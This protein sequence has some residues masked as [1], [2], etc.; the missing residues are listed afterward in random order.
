MHARV[1]VVVVVV[2]VGVAA[3][4]D[5]RLLADHL[6]LLQVPWAARRAPT[7]G[8]DRG[9][10]GAAAGQCWRC[11]RV[12]RPPVQGVDRSR[13][14]AEANILRVISALPSSP[15]LFGALYSPLGQE[16]L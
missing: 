16:S 13:C 4:G 15:T 8:V 9:R 2:V 5:L 11:A 6:M 12:R 10:R 7:P 1:H 3:R 14:S